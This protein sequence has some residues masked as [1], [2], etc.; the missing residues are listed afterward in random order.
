MHRTK[1]PTW[2][3][4]VIRMQRKIPISSKFGITGHFRGYRIEKI[5]LPL[6]DSLSY[7]SFDVDPAE[8]KQE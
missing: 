8:P 5:H 6:R 2:N 1:K 4:G 7:Y 3:F